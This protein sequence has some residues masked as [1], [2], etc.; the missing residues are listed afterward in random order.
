MLTNKPVRPSAEILKGLGI[1][2]FFSDVIGGDSSYG[3]KPDPAGLLALVDRAGV[4]P[5]ETLMVGDSP[6]DLATAERAGTR[7]CLARY[8]F[9]YRFD[10]YQFRGHEIFIDTPS[11]L[12][13]VVDVIAG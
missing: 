12:T 5:P 8:G 4:T 1:D 13:A 6:V 3:R 7:I 11:E 10:G 2:G 9:G